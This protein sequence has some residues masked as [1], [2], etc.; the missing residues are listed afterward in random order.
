MATK[1]F[2]AV[3]GAVRRLFGFDKKEDNES[4]VKPHKKNAHITQSSGNQEGERGAV[5]TTHDRI[6]IK[7]EQVPE[8]RLKVGPSSS[9]QEG[10]QPVSTPSANI[11]T[12]PEQVPEELK[13]IGQI[14]NEIEKFIEENKNSYIEIITNEKNYIDRNDIV[15]KTMKIIRSVE[16][17]EKFVK[18]LSGK[19][20]IEQLAKL[21]HILT[22]AILKRLPNVELKQKIEKIEEEIFKKEIPIETDFVETDK[23]DNFDKV[24]NFQELE[25]EIRIEQTVK[26]SKGNPKTKKIVK[27]LTEESDGEEIVKKLN[28]IKE[29]LKKLQSD[30]KEGKCSKKNYEEKLKKI[31]DYVKLLTKSAEFQK[32]I[33]TI[34]KKSIY[35]RKFKQILREP[36]S[37]ILITTILQEK[38][39]NTELLANLIQLYPDLFDILS[40]NNPQLL[41]TILNKHPNSIISSLKNVRRTQIFDEQSQKFS[42]CYFGFQ[43]L[44]NPYEKDFYIYSERLPICPLLKATANFYESHTKDSEKLLISCM[45]ALSSTLSNDQDKEKEKDLIYL[46]NT[47]FFINGKLYSF[48]DVFENLEKNKS[49]S[50]NLEKSIKTL[51]EMIKIKNL[52]LISGTQMIEEI[53]KHNKNNTSQ[54]GSEMPQTKSPT[55]SSLTE[56]SAKSSTTEPSIESSAPSEIRKEPTPKNDDL[57][58]SQ[59]SEVE[60][61]KDPKTIISDTLEK[62]CYF[63]DDKDKELVKYLLEKG[64]IADAIVLV[65][66]LTPESKMKNLLQDSIEIFI[67]Y[68]NNTHNKRKIII[69][70][71]STEYFNELSKEKKLKYLKDLKQLTDLDQETKDFLERQS[72]EYYTKMQKAAQIE[73]QPAKKKNIK[74]LFRRRNRTIIQA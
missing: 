46:L 13:N 35:D 6:V 54:F 47:P 30:H 71:I 73:T 18:F 64:R 32:F 62:Y 22:G 58:V 23:D 44:F 24:I 26:E 53:E 74:N 49:L 37:H 12:K 16:H 15:E 7:P 41:E 43:E 42:R 31:K 27:K 52:P 56:P 60:E 9:I 70:I 39:E 8:G 51:L 45:N 28:S 67:P 40:H 25:E 34:T 33:D 69:N 11:V 65:T 72:S 36:A 55:L 14:L 19:L 48:S 2:G 5:S 57:A 68:T 29:I 50:E 66:R 4:G 17:G 61:Y 20:N 3:R 59:K 21:D 10:K 38:R 63:E 1:I